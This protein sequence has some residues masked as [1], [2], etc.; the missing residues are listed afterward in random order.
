MSLNTFGAILTHAIELET[1]LR[2]YY[3]KAGSAEQAKAA[4]DRRTKLERVRREH[5]LEITLEPRLPDRSQPNKLPLVF[6]TMSH[7]RSMC[8]KHGA[9]LSAAPNS[10]RNWPESI[11]P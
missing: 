4:D 3:Q 2:D 8:G 9:P 7:R 11:K 10:T 1:R 5:V 6:I